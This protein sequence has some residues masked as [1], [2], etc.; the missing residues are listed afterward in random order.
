[1]EILMHKSNLYLVYQNTKAAAPMATVRA[2]ICI[3]MHKRTV[4]AGILYQPSRKLQ[5]FQ[6][7]LSQ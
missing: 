6:T 1:M 3:S 2:W 4:A 7:T 5:D